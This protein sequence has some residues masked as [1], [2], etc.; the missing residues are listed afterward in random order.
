MRHISRDQDELTHCMS[1]NIKIIGA[2]LAHTILSNLQNE[3]A[4][5][6]ATSTHCALEISVDVKGRIFDCGQYWRFVESDVG[7]KCKDQRYA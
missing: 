2:E 1:S 5:V 6:L 3:Y 7:W 4:T